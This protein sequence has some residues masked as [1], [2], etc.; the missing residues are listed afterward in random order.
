MGRQGGCKVAKAGF[1]II[2][3]IFGMNLPIV[4]MILIQYIL[5]YYLK[6]MKKDGKKKSLII[7]KSL[8]KQKIVS[9]FQLTHFVEQSFE[10]SLHED[11]QQVY[12]YK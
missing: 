9:S 7:K 10:P 11:F 1:T 12:P 5:E 8:N 2:R 4:C 6:L 3:D